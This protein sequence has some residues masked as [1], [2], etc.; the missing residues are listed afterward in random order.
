MFLFLLLFFSL[1]SCFAV[2][3]SQ[4]SW[5][6]MRYNLLANFKQAKTKDGVEIYNRLLNALQTC[7]EQKCPQELK[8][9]ASELNKNQEY[10]TAVLDV[11]IDFLPPL[12]TINDAFFEKSEYYTHF[13]NQD[14]MVE[15]SGDISVGS[16]QYAFTKKI[17]QAALKNI[18]NNQDSMITIEEDKLKR[19]IFTHI[20]NIYDELASEIKYVLGIYIKCKNKT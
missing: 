11:L 12:E 7:C 2:D 8:E 5:Q 15:T 14:D 13:W 9:M 3:Q 6:E 17:Y 19:L 10:Q 1:S 18:Q 4:V 16:E 20:M